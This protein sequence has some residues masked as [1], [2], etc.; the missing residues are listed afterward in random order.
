MR[1]SGSSTLQLRHWSRAAECPR[2]NQRRPRPLKKHSAPRP[3]R[4][5]RR[6]MFSPPPE[7]VTASGAQ[8]TPVH[9]AASDTAT[10]TASKRTHSA[11]TQSSPCVLPSTLQR[12]CAAPK[13]TRSLTDPQRPRG[14]QARC[15]LPS[16]NP[17]VNKNPPKLASFF[18]LTQ[19]MRKISRGTYA[20]S[21][22]PHEAGF[23][24]PTR[25]P[26]AIHTL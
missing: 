5:A 4:R 15:I 7:N 16:R 8:V 21:F 22:P 1:P 6:R 20:A 24:S 13:S 19:T 11:R 12:G 14:D 10:S 9:P 26:S 2:L 3:V 23:S 17:A 18:V 25:S